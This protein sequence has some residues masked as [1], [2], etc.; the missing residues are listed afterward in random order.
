MIRNLYNKGLLPK[1]WNGKK[2]KKKHLDELADDPEFMKV[3]E[4]AKQKFFEGGI[5]KCID[6][7]KSKYQEGGLVDV[8]PYESAYDAVQEEQPDDLSQEEVSPEEDEQ[9]KINKEREMADVTEQKT[10]YPAQ[11]TSYALR[12]ANEGAKVDKTLKEEYNKITAEYDKARSDW[13]QKR[14][15]AV[16]VDFAT[17]MSNG[18]T[19]Y[20]NKIAAAEAQIAGKVEIKAPDLGLKDSTLYQ[21]LAKEKPTLESQFEKYKLLKLGKEVQ[22]L[23]KELGKKPASIKNNL[24]AAYPEYREKILRLDPEF[25]EKHGKSLIDNLEKERR[26][27]KSHDHQLELANKGLSKEKRK[28]IDKIGKAVNELAKKDAGKS[29]V[30]DPQSQLINKYTLLLDAERILKTIRSGKLKGTEKVGL[31]LASVL[32]SS[33]QGGTG[34]TYELIKA[35]APA[36]AM[37]SAKGVYE[38]ISGEPVNSISGPMLDLI[39]EQVQGQVKFMKDVLDQKREAGLRSLDALMQNIPEKQKKIFRN[40]YTDT[41][42]TALKSPDYKL[43]MDE[44][45]RFNVFD[46][47]VGY[48]GEKLVKLKGKEGLYRK[49]DKGYVRVK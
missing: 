15:D 17:R 32:A 16:W 29:G 4:E 48:E 2:L 14:D 9:S 7:E 41:V 6:K 38:W 33:L 31:E 37:Q 30:R 26:Q 3:I 28:R 22:K 1:E 5:V 25:L 8:D 12:H 18:V 20:L 40:I 43:R 11:K 10:G 21:D 24:L 23:D 49:T 34:A 46:T 44:S 36:S 19:E 35:I 27:G 45:E 42:N 47:K 39:E 13:E